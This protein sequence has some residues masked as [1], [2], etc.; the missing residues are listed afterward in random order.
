MLT[1]ET[2]LQRPRRNRKT[3][4]IRALIEETH[5][6]AQDLVAPFFLIPG[7][8]R[9]EAIPALPGVCRLTLDILISE[10]ERL[11]AAGIPAIALFP[12]IGREEKDETASYALNEDGLIPTALQ[13]LKQELP[14]LC[15]ITD[16]A[17][18]P[19]TS[20]G[21]DGLIDSQG[22]V[23]NDATVEILAQMALLHAQAGADIVAP[24][25]MMDGRVVSIRK[26]LD[27][28]KHHTV[29]ILSYCA[30]Y[31]SAL[32]HPFRSA[33]DSQLKSGDKKGYQM[34][35]ANFREALREAQ[36]D[37]IEGA[38]MLMVK[39]ALHYLDIISKIKEAT[40]LPVC[41]YHV[42]G[43][44]AMVMAAHEK[45]MLDAPSVFLEALLSIKRAGADFIFTYAAPQILPLL[46]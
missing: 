16:I 15:V 29:A 43:E 9:E 32:Y 18:D 39:P 26:V 34:N 37:E 33:L 6:R 24:S 23:I 40:H 4:A 13:L 45:G 14:S 46:S 21:H 20:H 36:L 41:A 44:Y 12:V 19:F 27:A 31:A 42:S 8:S 1:Q 11:H 25:D 35:P 30:K 22:E 7:P 3:K 38:D 28:H 10:A 5:L 17:L 2:L